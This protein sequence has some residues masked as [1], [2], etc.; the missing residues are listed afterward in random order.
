[1]E[2]RFF[3]T[4]TSSKR[5]FT[6]IELLVVIAIIAVL[7]A[8]LFPVFASAKESA[9]A[10]TCLSNERQLGIASMM[11]TTDYDDRLPTG[12]IENNGSAYGYGWAGQLY[13]YVSGTGVYACPDDTTKSLSRVVAGTSYTLVPVSLT[14][15]QSL[16]WIAGQTSEM[17]A[18]SKTVMLT[19]TT[20]GAAAGQ[21][22]VADVTSP[23]ELGGGNDG[24]GHYLF[25][26]VSL[27]GLLVIGPG[28]V[29]RS[30]AGYMGGAANGRTVFFNATDYL[31]PTGWHHGLSNFVFCDGHAKALNGSRVST[32][33]T[34]YGNGAPAQCT[35]TSTMNQDA[36]MAN[37]CSFT[38]AG[39]ESEENWA[40]TFSPI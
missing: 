5:G 37:G 22:N 1:M 21:Y 28:Y 26:P 38:P 16:V 32:G 18:T 10:T 17:T 3:Q 14:L 34:Y 23:L 9:K 20:S 12:G 36:F 35:A 24:T 8:I 4:K 7:A 31:S 30:T 33:F 2:Q 39:T 11:Y 40:A 6:L 19:E 29:L 25:S 27:G 15:S 13:P